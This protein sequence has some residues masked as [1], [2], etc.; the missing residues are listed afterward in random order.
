[1]TLVILVHGTFSSPRRWT[2]QTKKHIQHIFPNSIIHLFDWEEPK[3]QTI[4]HSS[5][6][7]AA[8]ELALYISQFK[9]EHPNA[10]VVIIGHS[11]GANVAFLTGR[12]ILKD[13]HKPDLIISLGKPYLG[14]Y[15]EYY[16]EM[17][18]RQNDA[19]SAFWLRIDSDQDWVQKIASY[20]TQ[21][22]RGRIAADHSIQFQEFSHTE[23][24]DQPIV[25]DS[26]EDFIHSNP[27]V[28]KDV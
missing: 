17:S 9:D 22:K 3:C 19:T 13:T 11:H 28:Y 1:M 12:Y 4:L 10:S 8:A 5:R 18:P 15:N 21:T 2:E 7:N 26:I 20:Y 27:G 25:W 16:S 23:L 24:I 6:L 14:F